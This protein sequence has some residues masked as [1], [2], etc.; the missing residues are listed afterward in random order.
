[1]AAQSTQSS[2]LPTD[3]RGASAAL[4]SDRFTGACAMLAGIAGFLY[5]L[6]FVV[7]KNNLLIDLFLMLGALFVIPALT[8]LYNRVKEADATIASLAWIL[9]VVGA[10]GALIHG[11]Y[12]LAN[13]INPPAAGSTLNV[14]SSLP[15]AIDPRGLLTFGIAGLAFAAFAWLIAR[16]G[17]SRWLA[18]LGYLLAIMLVVLYLGRLIILDPKSPLIVVDGGLAGFIVNPLWYLW[19][20]AMLWTAKSSR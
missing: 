12:D 19:L 13:L 7:L 18:Y 11:G 4:A 2:Q 15:S 9:G 5:S 20:G 10:L 16:S 17:T 14:L 1:M 6:S 8:G 3:T